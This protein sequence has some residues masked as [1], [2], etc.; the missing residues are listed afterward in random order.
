MRNTAAAVIVVGLAVCV[1]LAGA[2]QE[3]VQA[4]GAVPG[5][6]DVFIEHNAD[7][8]A[9]NIYYMDALS[10]LSVVVSA[11]NGERFTLAGTYVMY[12]KVQSGAIM[13]ARS[14]GTLEAHPFIRRTSD[15]RSVDWVTSPDHRAVAWVRVTTAGG[16]ETFAAWA[17]GRGLRQLTIPSPAPPL[18]ITPVA[19]ADDMTTFFYAI[20]DPTQPPPDT[21]YPVYE[22]LAAYDL[23]AGEAV[24][25]PQE[26]NCPCGAAIS[27]DGRIFVRLEAP[28][29]QGPFA[30]HVWDLLPR[31]AIVIPAPD[32][33][34]VWAGDLL[35][36]E[37]GTLAVYSAATQQADGTRQYALL[38]VDSVTVRQLL[39]LGQ[40]PERYWP[41][42]FIDDDTALLLHND[43]GTYKLDWASG[44]L[45]R[46]SGA[47]Y[48]GAIT[49][50]VPG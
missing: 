26:P 23:L 46:V 18:V 6:L 32:L 29:G 50:T 27:P 22:H 36:N 30:L 39:V 7:T 44:D 10:G 1:L 9:T 5:W 45:L 24:A 49:A 34:L 11:D 4:Q 42:A 37:S 21:P 41:V 16:S 12:Q 14:D 25:L 40:T 3:W 28:G 47:L 13:R 20:T 8:G 43:E 17:D 15:D 31:A 33:P 48:L 19:L 35:L 38:V 2:P